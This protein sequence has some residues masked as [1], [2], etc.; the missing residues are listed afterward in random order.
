MRE[1]GKLYPLKYLYSA[2]ITNISSELAAAA[3]KYFGLV[4]C[5]VCSVKINSTSQIQSTIFHVT[6]KWHSLTVYF[7]FD[8]CNYFEGRYYIKANKTYPVLHLGL[9]YPLTFLLLPVVSHFVKLYT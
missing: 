4:F 6:L 8:A 9:S 2:C 7:I 1:T 3:K 5:E